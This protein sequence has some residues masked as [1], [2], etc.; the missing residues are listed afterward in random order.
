MNQKGKLRLIP[1]DEFLKFI[2]TM[3]NYSASSIIDY[4]TYFTLADILIQD[5]VKN[6]AIKV[7]IENN[8]M[9]LYYKNTIT[10]GNLRVNITYEFNPINL[11]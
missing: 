3:A 9:T 6:N 2:N 5:I 8:Q 10:R 11:K 1:F 4:N 7:K